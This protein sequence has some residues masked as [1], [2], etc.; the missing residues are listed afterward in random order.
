MYAL[1]RLCFGLPFQFS[2]RA[3]RHFAT[4]PNAIT[5]VAESSLGH[6]AGFL[7]THRE[8]HDNGTF[9]YIVTLDVHPSL[10][11]RGI[12]TR[13][14]RESEVECGT[15][16]ATSMRLH[17]HTGN[18]A[19]IAFYEHLDYKLKATIRNFYGFGLDAYLYENSIVLRPDSVGGAANND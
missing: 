8:P 4:S 19:A 15:Y 10:S 11:R 2:L 13:L 17:V 6:I 16:G 1:D 9:G 5:L 12:A 7:I 3:M 18:A 14:M